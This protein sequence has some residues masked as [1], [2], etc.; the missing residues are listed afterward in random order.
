[1][2]KMVEVSIPKQLQ[3]DFFYADERKL[4][5]DAE[6][7]QEWE[8]NALNDG[9]YEALFFN[10]IDGFHPWKHSEVVIPAIMQSWKEK[11]SILADLYAR[12][13]VKEAAPYMKEGIKY[14]LATLYYA[15]EHPIVLND[16]QNKVNQLPNVPVNFTERMTFI[17]SRPSLYQSFKAL[18]QI[19]I[20]LEKLYARITI[21]KQNLL[22]KKTSQS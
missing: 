9:G 11:Q 6:M 17:L 14:T 20:E 4:S 15:N 12:R 5:I 18:E 8:I 10:S 7:Y 19:M 21:K 3:D 2:T 16:W 13:A 22:R 1:M